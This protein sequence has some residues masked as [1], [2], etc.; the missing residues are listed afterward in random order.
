MDAVQVIADVL[1]VSE[2][3]THLGLGWTNIGDDELQALCTAI[4]VKKK[5]QELWLEGNRV[6]HRGLLSLADL[7]PD[8]LQTIVV[9]WNNLYEKESACVCSQDRITVNFTDE[10]MWQEW[11]KWVFKRCEVSSNEKLLAVLYKVCNMS[12]DS[13]EL[14]WAKTFYSQLSQLIKRRIQ[15]CTE[16]DMCKKLQ[17]FDRILNL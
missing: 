5:V 7:T 14:Q 10:E 1:K 9:I 3:I 15:C 6:S 4:Q 12:N 8:P 16:D 11:G 17:R 13:L 2:N